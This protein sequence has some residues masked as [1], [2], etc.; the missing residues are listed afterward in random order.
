MCE[1]DENWREDFLDLR[2][3]VTQIIDG[4]ENGDINFEEAVEKLKEAVKL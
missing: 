4:L 1:F 3:A 2:L